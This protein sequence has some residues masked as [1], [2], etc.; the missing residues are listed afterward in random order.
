MMH[1]D[2]DHSTALRPAIEQKMLRALSQRVLD[3]GLQILPLAIAQMIRTIG[4]VRGA[5]IVAIR[6]SEQW[7]AKLS[8]RR[9]DAQSF[10]ARGPTTMHQN[11]PCTQPTRHI[12]GRH[13]PQRIW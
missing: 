1:K 6:D 13:R 12:P 8:Q 10:V 7:Q 11:G 9:K 5:N 2:L 3:G 4:T